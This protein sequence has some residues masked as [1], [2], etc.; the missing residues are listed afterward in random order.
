MRPA[1]L[2]LLLWIALPASAQLDA[3]LAAARRAAAP[4]VDVAPQASVKLLPATQTTSLGCDLLTGLPLAQPLDAWRIAF[5]TVAGDF[6]VHTSVDGS[7]TQLCDIRAPNLG[8]GIIPAA[9]DSGDMPAEREAGCW[10][11]ASED[12]RNVRA[13]PRGAPV[14]KLDRLQQHRALGRNEA[15]DWLFYREGWVKRTGLRLR[16]DCDDLPLLDPAQAASGVIHFCPAGYAGFLQPRIGIGSKS[17]RSASTDF[18]SRLRAAPDPSAELLAEIPPRQILDAVLD[19]PACQGSYIWWKVALAG[20]VGWTIESDSKAQYYYLEPHQ[21]LSLRPHTPSDLPQR[22]SLRRIDS[23]AAPIDT[24]ATLDLP[25]A[26]SLAF[27]PDDSLLAVTSE[28]GAAVFSVPD[29][30]PVSLSDAVGDAL[31]W[32]L[33]QPPQSIDALAWSAAGDRLG[34]VSG[35]ELRIWEVESAALT[36]HY[37]FPLSLRDIAFSRD[38]RWLALTGASPRTRR[39]A[40]WIYDRQGDLALSRSLV[41]AGLPPAVVPA[42]SNSYGDFVYSSADKLYALSVANGKSRAVY[43]LAGMQIR[44]LTFSASASDRLL[45]LALDSAGMGWTA[46]VDAQ[47]ADAPGKTLRMA[48][49][50]LAFSQDGRFLAAATNERVVLLGTVE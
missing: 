41:A 20:I 23:P 19:G 11:R 3:A 9:S 7:L 43:Q 2:C 25:A 45:A 39:A 1:L 13:A 5:P 29:F 37:R 27:S 47:D 46:A 16:G 50:A 32:Q 48:A 34:I 18:A 21:R 42:P 49:K 22:A 35:R 8:A 44:D 36:W 26:R 10:L 31:A 4:F 6:A 28:S 40:L 12:G 15:G 17:A 30:A 38:G 24:I 33:A 14:A